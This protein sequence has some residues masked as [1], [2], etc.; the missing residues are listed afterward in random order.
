MFRLLAI[1]L[2]LCLF[3]SQSRADANNKKV[4]DFM[5]YIGI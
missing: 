4:F 5:I 3:S 1:L 2:I